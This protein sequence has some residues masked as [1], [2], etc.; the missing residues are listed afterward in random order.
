MFADSRPW[1][2][3]AVITL[4]RED[5]L[6]DCLDDIFAQE[7]ERFDVTVVDQNPSLDARLV[8]RA[9][10]MPERLR[11]IQML[12]PH[13]CNARNLAITRTSGDVLVFVDDDT[14][15]GPELLTNYSRAFSSPKI[16]G[17]AGW[18]DATDPVF[19]WHP[20]SRTVPAA[21][22]CNM[23]FRR[24]VIEEVG[25][26][27]ANFVAPFF[28]GEETEFAS[29]VTRAGY[30]ITV[31]PEALLFHARHVSGGVRPVRK[32]EYWHSYVSNQ[33]LLFRK[34]RPAW[35]RLLGP[36]WLLKLWF[37]V[38]RLGGDLVTV[39]GF[40]RAASHGFALARKSL[41]T[42]TFLTSTRTSGSG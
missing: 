35:Q 7:Y 9:S 25:G 28:H 39:S 8:E 31:C 32:P 33:T 26:W 15:F 6:L 2:N 18:I 37:T 40:A 29:R 4:G 24:D 30:E 17:V 1:I 21:I 10:K 5:V 36:I 41:K 3:V 34:S 23:A 16:G 11:V 27:D 14:R 12:P 38:R 19:A 42:K 13:M 22:G 20:E